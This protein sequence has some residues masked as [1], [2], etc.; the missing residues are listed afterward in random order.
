MYAISQKG[1]NLLLHKHF[2][3]RKKIPLM[4][5]LFW[6]LITQIA[7]I[8]LTPKGVIK[9]I[10]VFIFSRLYLFYNQK[11]IGNN[12]AI[13]FKKLFRLILILLVNYHQSSN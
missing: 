8:V 9:Y 2:I 10:D 7:V 11:Y 5:K 3:H 4:K 6:N 13:I 1:E 12:I